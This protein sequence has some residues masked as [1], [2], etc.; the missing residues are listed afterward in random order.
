L[1]FKELSV[2]ANILDRFPEHKEKRLAVEKAARDLDRVSLRFWQAL[3]DEKARYDFHKQ[4]LHLGALREEVMTSVETLLEADAEIVARKAPADDALRDATMLRE[5]KEQEV[6]L[7]P[8][9]SSLLLNQKA[10]RLYQALKL[11]ATEPDARAWTRM[12]RDWKMLLY[13]V[14]CF[15]DCVYGALLLLHGEAA[16]PGSSMST[17]LK[18]DKRGSP[19]PMRLMLER[20]VP[21]YC[22]WFEQ[23]KKVRDELKRGLSVESHWVA[24]E[25]SIVLSEAYPDGI[26]IGKKN[27]RRLSLDLAIQCLCM[28]TAVTNAVRAE[29]TKRG[30]TSSKR[31]SPET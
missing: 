29:L 14:R 15:Q 28:S 22:A 30:A 1:P 6:V 9:Q 8:H 27:V 17:G 3:E 31:T 25:H 11:N 2:N 18:E 5:G 16:G 19:K 20:R 13:S 26:Y 21:G 12:S 4:L 24:K 23:M 10:M 7:E